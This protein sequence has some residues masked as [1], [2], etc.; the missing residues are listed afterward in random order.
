MVSFYGI[1]GVLLLSGSQYEDLMQN[2]ITYKV[3]VYEKKGIGIMVLQ[4]IVVD[5]NN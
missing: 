4:T 5:Q 2:E 1:D 3:F